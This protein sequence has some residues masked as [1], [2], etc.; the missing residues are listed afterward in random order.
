MSVELH[1]QEPGQAQ[2]GLLNELIR[3]SGKASSGGGIF[4]WTSTAGVA[5]F[6]EHESFTDL[7]QRGTFELVIGTDTITT[8]KTVSALA[9][10][11]NR[12]TNLSVRAFVHD[13]KTLFHP[14]LGAAL[15]E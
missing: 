2:G 13:I 14:K 9:G 6:L 4:A 5:A 3:L 11:A 7:L 10:V 1:M 12:Y 8:T 15:L